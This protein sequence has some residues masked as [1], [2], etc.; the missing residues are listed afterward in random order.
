MKYN[1]L[2]AINLS[3]HAIS[4][5]DM[6]S[7]HKQVNCSI[8]AT[9]EKPVGISAMSQNYVYQEM[10]RPLIEENTSLLKRFLQLLGQICHSSVKRQG[11]SETPDLQIS[12]LL[13]I[14]C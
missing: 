5:K 3:S 6:D 1:L 10:R 14:H 4:S 2:Q 7:W 12:L 8:N 11:Y 9:M 13:Y